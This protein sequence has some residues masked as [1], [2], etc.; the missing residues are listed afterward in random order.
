MVQCDT[1]PSETQPKVKLE[2]RLIDPVTGGGQLLYRMHYK[3]HY[4]P[5]IFATILVGLC[6]VIMLL[7]LTT[8]VVAHRKLFKDFFTLRLFRQQRSWFDMHNIL[9]VLALPFHFMNTY[10]GLAFFFLTLMPLIFFSIYQGN[11]NKFA[12]ATHQ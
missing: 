3:L 1:L 6:T 2:K 12:N 5:N 9:S 8:G 11:T 10:S 7:G 4:L